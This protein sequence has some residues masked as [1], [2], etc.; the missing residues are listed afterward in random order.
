[1]FA[2]SHVLS[3]GSQTLDGAQHSRVNPLISVHLSRTSPMHTQRLVTK[4][5]LGPIKI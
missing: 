1:M 5:I 4:A 2:W 3:L